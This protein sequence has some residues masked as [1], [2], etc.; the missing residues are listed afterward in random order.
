MMTLRQTYGLKGH[1]H[2][3]QGIALGMGMRSDNN[4]PERAKAL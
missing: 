4:R 2:T 1:Q 3:A